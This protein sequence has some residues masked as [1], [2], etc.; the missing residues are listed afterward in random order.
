MR[1]RDVSI[2]LAPLALGGCG[3]WGTDAAEGIAVPEGFTIELAAGPPLVERPMIVDRDDEGR[4]YVAESSGSNDDVRRQLEERPHSILRLEDVDGDGRYDRRTVF[5]DKMMFPEG[6][7]WHDGSVYVAAPPSI[8]KLTDTDSD[9]V[10]DRREEWFDAK[11]L[12]P[13]ANDLHGP[14]LGLDGWIYWTKGAFAEQVYERPGRDPFVTRAA[15]IFRRR[16]SG[17]PV[18]PVLTGG[19]NNP[20]ELAFTA[21]GERLLT[22]TFLVHPQLGRRDGLLHAVYGGVYGKAHGVT[23]GHPTT[24]GYLSIMTHLGGSAPVGLA[25]YESAA[26]GEDYR[27]RLFATSFNLRKVTAH[28]LVPQGASFVTEDADFLVSD[29]RD[30]HPTDVMEDADGSLLVVN[31]G[32][33]YKLCCPTAQLTKPDVL[34]AIYRIRKTGAE[35]PA[36]PLGRQLDWE[37]LGA[38]RLTGLLGADRP[39]V[40]KRAIAELAGAGAVDALRRA[41]RAGESAE[42]RRNSVWALTRIESAAARSAVREA[43]A[44]P[45]P[46]VRQAALHSIALHR[47]AAAGAAVLKQLAQPSAAVKRV[48]AEALG[49]IG[50]SG[51]VGSLL[52]EAAATDDEV[53][54]H[55][56]VYALIEIA[57]PV[58]TR[59]GLSSA[60]PRSERAAMIA[61]D[62]MRPGALAPAE[63]LA[64][65]PS[66][67]AAVAEA[68]EWIAGRH[69]EWGGHLAGYLSRRLARFRGGDSAALEAQLGRFAATREVQDLLAR[70]AAGGGSAPAR[71]A[72]LAVMAA[73]PLEDPP[74]GWAAAIGSALQAPETLPAALRA[75]RAL[76]RPEKGDP[77]LERALLAAARDEARLPEARVLALEAALEA[78]DGLEPALFELAKS[79][80]PASA[81]V[82]A[83]GA[84]AR[85]IAKVQLSREQLLELAQ[86]LPAAGPMEL[87]LLVQAFGKAGDAELGESFVAGL[88]RSKGL[89]NLRADVLQT[90]GQ[91]Y[92]EPVRERLDA[93]L[94]GRVAGLA[95]Q[96][97]ALDGMLAALGDGDVRRG[98]AVFNSDAAACLACH[99][100]GHQGGRIGPDLTR[101]GQIRTRRDL[102]EAI[103]FPNASFVRSYEPIV[104]VTEQETLTGVP[105]EETDDHLLLAVNADEQARVFR[106]DIQEVRPGTVSVMPSGLDE[107]LSRGELADLL[108]FLE[109]TQWGPP[110]SGR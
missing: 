107:Q 92:P 1:L 11:T 55:S 9:G 2:L 48:A 103:V 82:K 50:W 95:E 25:R 87:P 64:R 81:P 49:R 63:V 84:A 24:G 61:L 78:L 39:A 7:L 59:H 77:L 99:A 27:G 8:W 41:L 56:L 83:R 28:R 33:W 17:G 21:E 53:L 58:R 12:T 15:H 66:A 13:C 42:A 47:D 19:M 69:P 34:G 23:D 91:A 68:A 79:Q 57:D 90:A 43:L 40:R 35:A 96:G 108:A 62:Q 26:F 85:V 98:Q 46:G 29:D 37:G 105:L 45:A 65:L 4:L 94:E 100:I 86:I 93:L 70:A 54:T 14:Y 38:D 52:A 67:D 10:A 71:R 31:T 88:T 32:G 18:E 16:V 101:I 89:A 60:S 104:V 36:D 75:A 44:D 3:F 110:G 102:L 73:A 109:A 76:P 5:A 74:A 97:A 80:V 6:V 22:A 72:A 106:A 30:F 51:A 20:V